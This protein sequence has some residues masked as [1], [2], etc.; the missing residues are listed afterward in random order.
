MKRT[1][2][3]KSEKGQLGNPAGRRRH[4]RNELA[5]DFIGELHDELQRRG[6]A[7]VASSPDDKVAA[8]SARIVPKEFQVGTG[9]NL[10]DLLWQAGEVGAQRARP[11]SGSRRGGEALVSGQGPRHDPPVQGPLVR[12]NHR[13]YRRRLW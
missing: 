12:Q 11:P 5:E 8:V 13:T 3:P 2:I 9:E 1:S 10:A 4:S 6:R 7:A